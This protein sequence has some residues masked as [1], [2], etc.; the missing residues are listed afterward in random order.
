M[1]GP[2]GGDARPLRGRRIA[3]TRAAEPGD[4]L[5]EG[6]SRA[7][8]AVLSWPT[9]EFVPPEDAEALRAALARAD[10]FD[11]IAFTSPRAVV[12]VAAAG[13]GRP[14]ATRV[15]AVGPSTAAAI[16]ALG[17]PVAVAVESGGAEA[18]VDR[19]AA[20]GRIA[21]AAVLFPAGSRARDALAEG[22]EASG[23]TVTRVTAY[24]TR[25]ARIDAGTIRRTLAAGQ[26]DAV[27]FTSP[28]AVSA[29]AAALG[30]GLAGHMGRTPAFAIGDTTAEALVAEGILPVGVAEP[31]T[32]EALVEEVVRAIGAEGR[33]RSERDGAALE[34]SSELMRRARA[35]IPGGVNSPVRAFGSVGGTPPFIRSASG[36]RIRD[37]DG[38]EYIDYVGSWGVAILGHG[39]A[40]VREAI[41]AVL[42]DG[43]SFGAPTEREVELA[44]LV[45]S[46]VPSVQ[47]LRL[48]NS[49]T[50]AT[51]S[52]VRLARAATGRDLVVKFRGGYHGHG[53]LF[54]VEAGSGAATLG[55]PSSPGVTA[56]TTADT[57]VAE[58]NDLDSVESL[59]DA[60]AG[61]IAAVIVEPVAGNMG[62]IPPAGKFLPGL[63]S[64]CSREGALLVFD[65]VMTGFRVALGGAQALYGVRPDLTTFGKIIG[66]GI[67]VGAYGGSRD[68]MEMVAPA[69]PVYQAGTLSGNPLA[70]AAGLA[71]L[72]RL[73]DEP[74][75]Y[76][77]LERLG[78]RLG[79]GMREITAR[80]GVPA[81]WNRVGSMFSLFFHDGPV[82][83]WPAASASDREL[84][85]RWFHG[86]LRRGVYLAPS[87]FEAGFLSAAHSEEDVDLT[88][89]AADAALGEALAG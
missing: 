18:L 26:C 66:G 78:A 37:I 5:R 69:G 51:M 9:I 71:T 39:P 35:C 56:G 67:P 48:V 49:G 27:T 47:S 43:T 23:A 21:G 41:A 74:D 24:R 84:F 25:D 14:P 31:N 54:L 59:F 38:N 11:W 1:T 89:E 86:L 80:R 32:L 64:L 75:I 50:E 68:L 22:L 8:A 36:A 33:D 62:C 30:G 28:S 42:P 7:G 29:L 44:E 87:P 72:R 63:R 10:D 88:I 79:E 61:R 3:V 40:E 15:A 34:R 70:T 81:A 12:S 16:R 58:Y 77:R 53:D 57:L 6:L 52:A 65:E 13:D 4:P 60:H 83:D 55:V 73:R 20:T 85:G 82:R 46:L 19:L 17:W 76:L 45:T 2:S